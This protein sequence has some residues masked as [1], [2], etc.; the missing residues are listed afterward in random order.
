MALG[1]IVLFVGAID[2]DPVLAGTLTSPII[3]TTMVGF[4]GSFVVMVIVLVCLP[5]FP[6]E[7]KVALIVLVFPGSIAESVLL[8]A[9]QPQLPFTFLISRGVFPVLVKVNS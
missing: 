4:L 9:V 7:L 3:F 2:F 5:C 1:A 6:L 8:T